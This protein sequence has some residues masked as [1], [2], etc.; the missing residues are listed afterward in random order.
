MVQV[1]VL[2]D[3][4]LPESASSFHTTSTYNDVTFTSSSDV[5]V[6]S[7]HE[8]RLIT[9]LFVSRF[10]VRQVNGVKLADIGPTVF[11]LCLCVCL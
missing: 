5:S 8:K 10:Y 4:D 1:Q 11:T 3:D 6:Y 9:F 2:K 7:F